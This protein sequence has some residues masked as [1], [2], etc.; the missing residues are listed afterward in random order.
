MALADTTAGK[1][2][3]SCDSHGWPWEDALI[4]AAREMVNALINSMNNQV[5]LIMILL[6]D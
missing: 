5:V 4:A 2:W 3:G 6:N 1:K